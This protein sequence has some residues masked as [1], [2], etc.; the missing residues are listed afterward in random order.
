[1]ASSAYWDVLLDFEVNLGK[2]L[3][4]HVVF[5]T[6]GHF[7]VENVV[8]ILVGHWWDKFIIC[9]LSRFSWIHYPFVGINICSKLGSIGGDWEMSELL[10]SIPANN[11]NSLSASSDNS[12]Y[13]TVGLPISVQTHVSLR[14]CVWHCS[15]TRPG[16]GEGKGYNYAIGMFCE[17]RLSLKQYINNSLSGQP[18]FLGRI[19]LRR[20]RVCNYFLPSSKNDIGFKICSY[21]VC[22]VSVSASSL[23]FHKLSSASP[24]SSSTL[25][26]SQSQSHSDLHRSQSGYRSSSNCE[27]T[28]VILKRARA[29]GWL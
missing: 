6:M 5:E 18:L 7:I 23:S 4:L 28:C 8:Q 3:I 2:Q 26:S 22:T 14:C 15:L 1:M 29:S 25:S 12:I 20:A 11:F 9:E 13:A 27:Y 19:K 21:P 24:S 17:P 16:C 10:H